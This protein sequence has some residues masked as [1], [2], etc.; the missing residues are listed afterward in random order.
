MK[1]CPTLKN[2]IQRTPLEATQLTKLVVAYNACTGS[3]EKLVVN[4]KASATKL[5]AGIR[6]GAVSNSMKYF[7]EKSYYAQH[8]FT[9]KM[10]YTAGV[11]VNLSFR[12]KISVQPE[13]LLT[14]KSATAS[15]NRS[16][17]VK[18]VTSFSFTYLQIPLSLYY[19]L[20][21]KRIRP[22]ASIG[23]V[24]GYA[25]AK[26]A[27]YQVTGNPFLTDKNPVK[28][29]KDEYGY[30]GGAGILY[31]LT[32]K[33]RFGVEYIYENTLSNKTS[34]IEKFHHSSH[35]LTLRMSL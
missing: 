30:R 16:S 8:T 24:F 21:T 20:P 4:S 28:V 14:Q 32:P 9:S 29:D 10:G 17:L 23:G 2:K 35:N 13:I 3:S 25:V 7:V 5:R 26:E 19:T 1:D 6:M 18:E 15:R 11:F 31:S 33:L 12:D 27:Y 34:T 22:F